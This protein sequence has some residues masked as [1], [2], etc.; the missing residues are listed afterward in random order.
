M[1]SLLLLGLLTWITGNPV[2][3]L[4][5]V[6]LVSLAGYGYLSARIFQV[7]RAVRRW[8]TVRELDRTVRTNPHDATAHADLGRL[9]VDAG[10]PS[11]ALPHLEAAYARAPEVTETVY[12]LGAAR[13]RL[14]DEGGGR[15]LVEEALARDPR[16][17]YGEPYLRLGDYYLD[18]GRAAEALVH[19]ER[20]VG[21]H[22]SSVE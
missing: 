8:L 15:S 7:P 9:L 1:R 12:Y 19:L 6:A 18:R 14:G 16:I 13:L 17:R 10:W 20:F 21:M 4:V 22:A 11:R 2:L 5:I 3:A